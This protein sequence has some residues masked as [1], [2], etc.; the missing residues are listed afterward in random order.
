VCVL[1][2]QAPTEKEKTDWMNILQRAKQLPE[3]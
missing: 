1:I 3:P 2:T